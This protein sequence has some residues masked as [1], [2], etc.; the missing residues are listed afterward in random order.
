M[1]HVA[2]PVPL[3]PT[4][5]YPNLGLYRSG[6]GVFRKEPI[7]GSRTAATTLNRVS[8]GQFIYSKNLAFQ[9]AYAQVPMEFDG[10]F[11]SGEL[12]TF[13][14]HA[15]ELDARWLATYMQ[16]ASNRTGIGTSSKGLSR[17]R[18]RLSV[19]SFLDLEIWKPPLA[20]QRRARRKI[21][22][23]TRHRNLRTESE[24]LV[25][26]LWLSMLHESMATR[27]G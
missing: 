10:F 6:R 25:A 23:L 17:R 22:V 9:G 12:A 16:S 2:H 7:D 20:E 14:T 1:E 27:T 5:T 19:D 4:E 11:V 8:A 3:D 21:R 24:P 13:Q 26:A 15:A 18:Q